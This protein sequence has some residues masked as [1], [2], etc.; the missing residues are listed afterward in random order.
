[1]R[2]ISLPRHQIQ[3]QSCPIPPAL[4]CGQGLAPFYQAFAVGTAAWKPC[5]PMRPKRP[6]QRPRLRRVQ[7]LTREPRQSDWLPSWPWN[8]PWSS[9]RLSRHQRSFP[10]ICART[11][12]AHAHVP[13]VRAGRPRQLRRCSRHDKRHEVCPPR[14]REAWSGL[15]QWPWPSC[16]AWRGS[17]VLPGVQ[18]GLRDGGHCI[19]APE[20]CVR[21]PA[22]GRRSPARTAHRACR[23]TSNDAEPWT[24]H[25]RSYHCIAGRWSGILEGSACSFLT[26]AWA[27]QRQGEGKEGGGGEK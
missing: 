21:L 24:A 6:C 11:Q 14:R 10:H 17:R 20:G 12:P 25:S 8:T 7:P 23:H 9:W 2:R 16:P 1:M 18:W 3:W 22:A 5:R 26:V 13:G 15:P 4:A 27:C 19:P